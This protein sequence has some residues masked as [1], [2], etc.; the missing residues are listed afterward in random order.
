VAVYTHKDAT[1]FLKQ[2]AGK[3]IFNADTLELYAIDRA[4]CRRDRRPPRT[5]RRL[6]RVGQ[7]PRAL[8]V[9]RL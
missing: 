9:D 3:T 7:R 8:F 4:L 5:S 1:Q 6:Q 2:L